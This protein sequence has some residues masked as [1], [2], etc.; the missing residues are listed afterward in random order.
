MLAKEQARRIEKKDGSWYVNN[1]GLDLIQTCFRKAS[2]IF[3]K[4]ESESKSL[5]MEFGSAIHVALKRFY[6]TSSRDDSLLQQ[7]IKDFT[8]SADQI[9][10]DVAEGERRSIKNGCDILTVFFNTYK[11]DPWEVYVDEH[12]PFVERKF[13]VKIGE[14]LFFF[15]TIDT[16]LKNRET[17]ELCVFDH[18]TASSLGNQFATKGDVNHQLTG[19]IFACQQMGIPVT[20]GAFQGLKVVKTL[21]SMEVMR[22]FIARSPE[23]ISEWMEW[24]YH[25]VIAWEMA[26]KTKNFPMNGSQACNLYSGCQYLSVCAAPKQFREQLLNDMNDKN[27][28]DEE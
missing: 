28:G 3:G 5:A 11:N 4:P 6:Q 24:V 23:N 21:K 7:M 22:T 2:Y 26:N 8:D 17:G 27:T 9:V 12:G 16:L 14:N 25:T 19:Y 1:S 18:K 15:G 10:K 13:E 20:R